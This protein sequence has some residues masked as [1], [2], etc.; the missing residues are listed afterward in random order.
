MNDNSNNN[1]NIL[2]FS[3]IFQYT[4]QCLCHSSLLSMMHP[5]S[6]FIVLLP[7]LQIL[8]FSFSHSLF[9]SRFEYL[10][11]WYNFCHFLFFFFFIIER[12]CHCQMEKLD[13]NSIRRLHVSQR[14]RWCRIYLIRCM[15]WP[16]VEC[17]ILLRKFFI[18]LLN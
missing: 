3:L 4:Q 9:H 12:S 6:V 11:N 10:I 14:M 13:L 15:Y 8:S 16:D 7:L 17:Q 1:E 18:F 2:S 5:C